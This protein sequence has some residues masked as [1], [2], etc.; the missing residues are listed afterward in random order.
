MV[1][2]SLLEQ[3]EIPQLKIVVTVQGFNC[4]PAIHSETFWWHILSSVQTWPKWT[5]Y[6]S[7]IS[8]CSSS[9]LPFLSSHVCVPERLPNCIT[10]PF[11]M[12]FITVARCRVHSPQILYI[13][14][15]GM[16]VLMLCLQ[17][18]CW[19]V[20]IFVSVLWLW[21]LRDILDATFLLTPDL[22]RSSNFII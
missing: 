10:A 5:Y 17:Y 18:H 8:H 22:I 1:L 19:D 11:Y 13:Q 4:V 14:A 2:Y 7:S 20:D 6:H 15:T 21:S 3:N 9:H 12:T 16:H